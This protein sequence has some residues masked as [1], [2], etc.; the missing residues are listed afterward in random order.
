MFF[1]RM[2]LAIMYAA[3]A[4]EVSDDKRFTVTVEPAQ[5]AQ[6]AAQENAAT[7]AAEACS[8]VSKVFFNKVAGGE[9]VVPSYDIFARTMDGR[10]ADWLGTI[11]A[12]SGIPGT[13]DGFFLG[14][15]A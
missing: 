3:F 6:K 5:D 7:F 4:V 10:R 9:V 1:E 11:Y 2:T 15:S 8:P 12:A 14:Y 13:P